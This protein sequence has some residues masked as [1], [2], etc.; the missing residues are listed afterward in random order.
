MMRRVFLAGLPVLI[1]LAACTRG[2]GPVIP[3]GTAGGIYHD[4]QGWSIRV[5]PGW[6]VVPFT[7]SAHGVKAAG[8]QISN[9]RLSSPLAVPGTPIQAG[10]LAF[11]PLGVA[12]VIGTDQDFKLA[13][14]VPL[15]TD[16]PHGPPLFEFAC[17]CPSPAPLRQLN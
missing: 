12:L 4:P 11:P 8:A 9:V 2:A 7:L 17:P 10:G 13:R 14:Q 3:T 15:L 6:R 1:F 16:G 5:E